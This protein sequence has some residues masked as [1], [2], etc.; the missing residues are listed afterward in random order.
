MKVV[1]F[2]ECVRERIEISRE[3]GLIEC[4]SGFWRLTD[5]CKRNYD[6]ESYFAYLRGSSETP[7]RLIKE[8]TPTGIV[9]NKRDNREVLIESILV[10]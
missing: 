8:E 6:S 5:K 3:Y 1:P 4:I 2:G 7:K 9:L 10:L